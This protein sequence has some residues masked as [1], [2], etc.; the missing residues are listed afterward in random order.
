MLSEL[1]WLFVADYAGIVISTTQS[2]TATFTSH[3][4]NFTLTWF[5]SENTAFIDSL[6]VILK[7]AELLLD[8]EVRAYLLRYQ[9]LH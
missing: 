1:N 3:I 5:A 8:L 2:V 9:L 6:Q 4:A 7:S